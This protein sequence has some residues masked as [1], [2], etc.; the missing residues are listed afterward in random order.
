MWLFL[1]EPECLLRSCWMMLHFPFALYPG[2][3]FLPS[4]SICCDWNRQTNKWSLYL[5]H[6]FWRPRVQASRRMD[7]SNSPCTQMLT[8]WHRVAVP[9]PWASTLPD[10]QKFGRLPLKQWNWKTRARIRVE[11]IIKNNRWLSHTK[12]PV[13]FRSG[14]ETCC[15]QRMNYPLWKDVW[16]AARCLIKKKK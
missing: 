7:R 14:A 1:R 3:L 10:S 13:E 11:K 8:V 12:Y 16:K 15:A 9:C 4:T 2:L 5:Y 6:T